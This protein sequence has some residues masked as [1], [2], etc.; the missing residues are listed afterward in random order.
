MPVESKR[1]RKLTIVDVAEKAGVSLMTVSRVINSQHGVSEETSERIRNL[2]DQMGYVPPPPAK[3]NR[4]IK[5]RRKEGLV[6]ENI[7]FMIPDT[8]AH[9]MRTPI[10]GAMTQGIAGVLSEKRIELILSHLQ[11]DGG[12]PLCIERGKVDGV[13]MRGGELDEKQWKKLEK[14]PMVEVFSFGGQNPGCDLVNPDV[15]AG[16]RMGVL[17]LISRGL[18][19]VAYVLGEGD[20]PDPPLIEKRQRLKDWAAEQGVDFR[21]IEWKHVNELPQDVDGILFQAV[22]G[23]DLLELL[24]ILESKGR[25]PGTSVELA[26]LDFAGFCLD[27]NKKLTMVDLEMSVVGAKAAECLLSRMRDPERPPETIL[28]TPEIRRLD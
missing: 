9:A 15:E 4:R 1:K 13:I 26:V 5:G 19:R 20:N 6:T 7:T 27:M 3:R 18:Q 16:F 12:L 8:N 28:V 25:H 10:I 17:D 11:R 22:I 24:K 23:W 21:I 2:I 14:M